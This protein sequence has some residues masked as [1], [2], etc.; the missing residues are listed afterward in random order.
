MAVSPS[1]WP[2]SRRTQSSSSQKRS[3]ST[4]SH[5]PDGDPLSVTGLAVNTA[6]AGE[7]VADENG[8]YTF[9]PTPTTTAPLS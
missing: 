1:P 5:D 7:I 3:S 8:G 6:G 2:T 4:V 9:T